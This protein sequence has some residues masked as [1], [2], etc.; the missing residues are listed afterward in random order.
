MK[1]MF[2]GGVPLLESVDLWEPDVCELREEIRE[3][4]R[5]ACRPL[6]AYA[7]QYDRYLELHNSD[8]DT[9]LR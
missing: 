1:Q 6:R 3:A 5:R 9:L 8:I 2:F 7:A 4:L